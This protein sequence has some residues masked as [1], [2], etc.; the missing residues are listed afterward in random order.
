MV[1]EI[2]STDQFKE[3]LNGEK[4]VIVDFTA[5]WCG[6]C[7]T[8]APTYNKLGMQY[9]QFVKAVKI[10]VD[11]HEDIAAECEVI[12]MPTFVVFFKGVMTELVMKG[13]NETGLEQLFDDAKALF[14]DS[15]SRGGVGG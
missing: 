11:A 5:T 2:K 9:E 4:P 3:I 13:A 14:E 7:K 6:P 15:L 8:I 12:A 10:D 1:F